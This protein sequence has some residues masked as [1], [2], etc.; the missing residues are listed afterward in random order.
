MNNRDQSKPSE[1]ASFDEGYQER[2]LRI[3]GKLIARDLAKGHRGNEDKTCISK[4]DNPPMSGED[5]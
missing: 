3:L 1:N 2:G 4:T 5:A